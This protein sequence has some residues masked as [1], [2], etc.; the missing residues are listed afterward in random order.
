VLRAIFVAGW[1]PSEPVRAFDDEAVMTEEVRSLRPLHS[2]ASETSIH[3]CGRGLAQERRRGRV[4]SL[5]ML[6]PAAARFWRA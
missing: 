1:D 3:D 6:P 4:R 2:Y 5:A